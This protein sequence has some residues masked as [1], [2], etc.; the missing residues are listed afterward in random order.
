MEDDQGTGKVELVENS[1]YTGTKVLQTIDSW[2]DT[3]IQFD[4]VQGSLNEGTVYL[5]VT[6]NNGDRNQ[7]GY[8]LNFGEP[9]YESII[10]NLNPDHLWM[11]DNSYADTGEQGTHPANSHSTGT[12]TFV[13][14]AICR[15]NTYSLECGGGTDRCGPSNS[16]YMNIGTPKP[17]RTMGGWIQV[18]S[19]QKAM[20]CI[21]EEGAQIRNY[22]FIMGLGNALLCQAVTEDAPTFNIQVYSDRPI[23][24]NRP[25]HICFRFSGNTYDN[26]FDF[27]LDGVKMTRGFPADQQPDMS[28]LG[29]HS[30]DIC[31][32]G[33]GTTLEVGGTDITFDETNSCLY[34]GWGTW[35]NASTLTDSEIKEDLFEAGAIPLHPINRSTESEMQTSLESYNNTTHPD[36][37]LIF[38]IPEPSDQTNPTFTL[39][40]QLFNEYVSCHVRWMGTGTLTIRNS[41][42]SNFDSTKTSTPNGGTINV[43]NTAQLNITVKDI[44]TSNVI[45]NAFVFILAD[46]GGPLPVDDTVT[47]TRSDTTATV[48]HTTHGL[49]TNNKVLIKGA[50]QNEYNGIK[51]ISVVDSNTYTY[52]VSGNPS[53][54]AT[55]TITSTAVIISGTT[56][57]NG[58]IIGEI[59]FTSDQPVTGYARKA[60]SS[61]F[62]KTGNYSGVIKSNGTIT[63][64]LLIE[65]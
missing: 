3:S 14:T 41:G 13:S 44:N 30:G 52:T 31:F 45:S 20:V 5:F 59:D 10:Q 24:I 46:T 57:E 61:P 56:D 25:V 43:I 54:P 53:S 9:L 34:A 32:G 28:A 63:T 21:Y 15:G 26:K 23:P 35:A 1:D 8:Q 11:F 18:D 50:N 27:F 16:D 48:T 17:R 7:V 29:N 38:R 65:D 58:Q 37:P 40:N 49:V 4:S 55:G 64:I 22:C 62:Y 12:P 60:S 51:T 33:S 19:I 47:I 39:T 2:S 42:T 6:N 36:W